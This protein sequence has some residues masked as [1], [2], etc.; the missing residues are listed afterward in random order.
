[1]IRARP[2][3][4][5]ASRHERPYR[6]LAHRDYR[7][8]WS[9]EIFSSTGTQI[10]RVAVAWQVFEMTGDPLQLGL[11]GLVRFVPLFLFGL[12]GGML[13][14]RYDR[15]VTLIVA[16]SA[17]L[18]IAAAFAGLTAT[19]A[20]TLPWIYAL[21]ATSALLGAVASPTRHALIPMLVP[22]AAMPAAMTM[23]VLAM[24]T[25]GMVGPAVGGAL[26]ASVGIAPS[27]AIDAISFGLVAI[28]ALA[29]QTRATR[30]APMAS[31]R[32]AIVE[33]LRF[34]RET[35]VLLGTMIL[36]FLATFFG[37]STTLM[38]IF[39]ANILGGGPRTLGLLLSAPAAGAVAGA[40]ILASRRPLRRPGIGILAAIVVY[41]LSLIAFALSRNLLLSLAFLAV[42]GAADSVSVAQRHTLRNLVTPNRLRGRVAA[43]HATFAGGGPQPG[44][45]E[46]GLVASWTSAPAA[47]VIGGAGTLLA[48]LLVAR[49]IPEIARYRWRLEAPAEVVGAVPPPPNRGTKD[50]DELGHGSI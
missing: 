22:D 7:M 16:Q 18:L 12:I 14:D 34:L 28:T 46:A 3:S 30:G 11:L 33:G 20:I 31:G 35:P 8:I 43:A 13:A 23:E 4:Q 41:G 26:V 15:R 24:Q 5:R 25:A 40:T 10:Q 48:A 27:Y 1:M 32:E 42:S 19:G 37:A 45:F 36:D 17:Q 44:E 47:V 39:A 29:L 50:I 6:V 9:A 38:P 2:G 21:T 49:R